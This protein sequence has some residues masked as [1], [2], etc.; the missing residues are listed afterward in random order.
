MTPL[1]KILGFFVAAL[2]GIP[3]LFATIIAVGVTNS[4]ITPEVMSDLPREM[5]AEIPSTIDELYTALETDKNIDDDKTKIIIESM[6]KTS[7]SPREIMEKSGIFDWMKE[8]LSGSI[9]Q[10][11]EV[12]RGERSPDPILL[13]MRPLKKAIA[14][15]SVTTYLRSIIENLPECT[16]TDIDEWKKIAFRNDWSDGFDLDEFPSCRPH[17][18]TISNE[19][20]KMFQLRAINEMP[21]SVEILDK[22]VDLPVGWNFTKTISSVTY[23]LFIFPAI[24]IFLGSLI[25][26]TSKAGFFRWAGIST[27]T[28]G[29]LAF[30]LGSLLENLIPI[31]ELSFRYDLSNAIS[32]RFEELVISKTGNLIEMFF[33]SLFAP[34]SKLG[35]TIAIIGLI[36]FALSFLMNNNERNNITN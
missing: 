23:A 16:D 17:G 33:N 24:F 19:L 20:I 34:A 4:V 32:S 12:L 6:K 30:G 2:I 22:W 21:D 27:M 28:G 11:G 31:S 18:L 13:D 9:K 10:F 29:L 7:V 1:R 26:A 15:N 36:L 3:I 25:A 8:E 35:G 5:I 14:H